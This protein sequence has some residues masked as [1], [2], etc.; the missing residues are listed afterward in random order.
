MTA[1]VLVDIS[2]HGLGH[3]AQTAPVLNEI[4]RRRPNLRLTVHSGLP[5]ERLAR[6]ITE[7]FL[8]YQRASDFGFVMHNAID[9]DLS[10]SA[11]A[12]QQAHKDWPQRVASLGADYK[13]AGYTAVLANAAYLPLAAA[14]T[15][16]IP[17]VGMCSLNWLDLFR[18]YF[19]A[20]DWAAPIGEQIETA[21]N[22]GDI[23][24]GHGSLDSHRGGIS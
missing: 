13:R 15:A 3:L 18:H 16:G 9:I 21:Y 8:H 17:A 12:Y 23:C 22:A 14:A 10:A 19:R 1:H 5:R 11:D 24:G 6:R 7:P 20:H 4:R 2:A